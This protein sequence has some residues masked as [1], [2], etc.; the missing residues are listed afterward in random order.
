MNIT[1]IIKIL[2]VLYNMIPPEVFNAIALK[3]IEFLRG[4][5]KSDPEKI[6]VVRSFRQR[7]EKDVFHQDSGLE[8]P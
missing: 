2:L 3:L 7:I 1:K 4:L 6:Q 5:E 8:G